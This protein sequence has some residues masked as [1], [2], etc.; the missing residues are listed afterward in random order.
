VAYGREYYGAHKER[1]KE[2]RKKYEEGLTEEKSTM[3][4]V[5][6]TLSAYIRYNFQPEYREEKKETNLKQ[7]Y[8]KKEQ[9]GT[10]KVSFD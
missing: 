7:Y 2:Y 3:R 4:R 10:V 5:K 6:S 1:A 9:V 8:T